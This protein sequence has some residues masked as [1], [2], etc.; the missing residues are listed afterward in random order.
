[1]SIEL[2]KSYCLDDKCYYISL[3]MYFSGRM[4]SYT[5][6]GKLEEAREQ[7]KLRNKALEKLRPILSSW[8][9][10][11]LIDLILDLYK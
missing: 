10:K 9:Y 4:H 7:E 6:A 1:M 11:A 3:V 5:F 8:E 2:E